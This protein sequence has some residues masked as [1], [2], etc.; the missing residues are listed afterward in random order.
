MNRFIAVFAFMLILGKPLAYAQQP[1][2]RIDSSVF[3]KE[4]AFKL[5]PIE[6]KSPWTI[7]FSGGPVFG[8]IETLERRFKTLKKVSYQLG[9]TVNHRLAKG[10]S[11]QLELLLENRAFGLQSHVDGFR[12]TDTSERICWD[13]FYH[14]DISY[15][16]DYVHLPLLLRFERAHNSW[17]FGAEAGVFLS[18]LIANHQ[19]GTETLFLD[20]VG[21]QSF[22]PYGFEPGYT[23]ILYHG[24]TK[25]LFNTSDAGLVIGISGGYTLNQSFSIQANGRLQLGFSSI[26]ESPQLPLL[27]FSGYV[28]RLGLFYQ[29]PANNR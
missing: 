23:R 10:M 27:N 19:S 14:Y 2:S 1:V 13:C 29:L 7:G 21:A 24:K 15:V 5:Q 26:Y 12:I 4:K 25:N 17:M 22:I 20:P 18:L 11:V 28:I 8:H 6:A 9:F 3:I 16:T